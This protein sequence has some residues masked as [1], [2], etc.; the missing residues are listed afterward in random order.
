MTYFSLV[1]ETIQNA[2]DGAQPKKVFDLHLLTSL[3]YRNIRNVGTN[4]YLNDLSDLLEVLLKSSTAESMIHY[5]N[6]RGVSVGVFDFSED[7]IGACFVPEHNRIL[8]PQNDLPLSRNEKSR[9]MLSLAHQLRRA[10]QYHVGVMADENLSITDFVQSYRKEEADAEAVTAL[11]AWELRQNGEEKSWQNW[12]ASPKGDIPLAF[13][14]QL[15]ED[16]RTLYNGEAL[17]AAYYSWGMDVNR[18]KDC[19]DRA[20]LAYGYETHEAGMKIRV[21][22][23][24]FHEAKKENGVK[25]NPLYPT[26]NSAEFQSLR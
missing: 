19:D 18:I 7:N 15:T 21:I 22:P 2:A 3:A 1:L 9:M 26:S 12:I 25:E 13:S 16:P 11:V 4:K 10:W 5:L 14:E 8:L 17:R 20:L 6:D 24:H 23:T